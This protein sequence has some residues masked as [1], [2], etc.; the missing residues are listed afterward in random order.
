MLVGYARTSTADQVAGFEAQTGALAKAGCERLF[1]EQTSALG[2]RPQ[3]DAMLSFVREGDA[4][5]VTKVDRLAR[6]VRH[7][8]ELHAAL[9]A[10]GVSLRIL[11]FGGQTVATDTPHGRLTLTMFAAIAEFERD[12]MLERQRE[13]IAKA[14]GEGKYKGRKPTARAHAKEVLALRQEGVAPLAI[15][16]RLMVGKSSVYRILAESKKEAGVSGL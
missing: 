2:T 14:K 3:L 12:L 11:D 9:Q 15:A 7:L 6:S 8:L 5:V 1:A 10:K 16:K 13:G 4:V